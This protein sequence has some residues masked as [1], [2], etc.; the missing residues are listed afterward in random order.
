MSYD[1]HDENNSSEDVPRI[2]YVSRWMRLRDIE[3]AVVLGWSLL[4]ILLV[5]A[6]S[7]KNASWDADTICGIAIFTMLFLSDAY[8]MLSGR[9]GVIGVETHDEGLFIN[10]IMR[11]GKTIPWSM[12]HKVELRGWTGCRCTMKYGEHPR[13]AVYFLFNGRT[14]A[15]REQRDELIRVIVKAARLSFVRTNYWGQPVYKRIRR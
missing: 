8:V 9:R 2:T 7:I 12:L 10:C 5:V 15:E 14:A 11:P 1:S 6:S 4:V 3:L 13:R